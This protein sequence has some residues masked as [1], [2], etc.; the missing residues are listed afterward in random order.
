MSELRTNVD[1]VSTDE[2]TAAHAPIKV[3]LLDDH[4][5]VR[6]GVASLLE[7]EPDIQ[8]IGEASTAQQALARI[9]ALR[10]DVA[11]LDVRLPDGDG[12]AVC[13]EI[14]SQMPEVA[15]LMLTS[16]TDDDALFDA[17]M[18][19]AAGFVLKQ[20]HGTD[21]VGAV[22]TVASGQS[23]L[24]PRSTARM[25]ARLRDQASR[26]DPLAALSDQERRIL[27]LI[28]EGLTNRQ[29]G[30]RM[31]LAEKT[32]KNYV[33]NLLAKLDMQRRTQAAALA[34]QL[35]AEEATKRDR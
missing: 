7:T 5:V 26:K 28:G 20:I 13:R 2:P 17:V 10:P 24:D 23:L 3:F 25:M 6:R 29:I 35:K 18:A 34:A 11:V 16:F 27:E 8:V 9:P 19:G 4:E 12:V 30:G 32:V 14:R 33:S 31:Y 1:V 21:L 22:R 15:C